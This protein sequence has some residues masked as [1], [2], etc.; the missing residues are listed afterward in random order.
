MSASVHEQEE[1]AAFDGESTHQ[2]PTS[3]ERILYG[4]ASSSRSA[5]HQHH[6][7][8]R[9][10]SIRGGRISQSLL[11]SYDEEWWRLALPVPAF[12]SRGASR[13]STTSRMSRPP[14]EAGRRAMS[15]GRRALTIG[16]SSAVKRGS[17][18]SST[19]EHGRASRHAIRGIPDQ[20]ELVSRLMNTSFS[21]VAQQS[22]SAAR[23]TRRPERSPSNERLAWP[24]YRP[25]R[26]PVSIGYAKDRT[27]DFHVPLRGD[28]DRWAAKYGAY[29]VGAPDR[30]AESTRR[31]DG[32]QA[33]RLHE[34]RPKLGQSR[35]LND[36]ERTYAAP[37]PPVFAYEPALEAPSSTAAHMLFSSLVGDRQARNVRRTHALVERKQE[38][39]REA[40]AQR[41]KLLEDESERI[42]HGA[43]VRL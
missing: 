17:A 9:A 20:S 11:D 2:R 14:S 21:S 33:V 28:R 25:K 5:S 35:S 15:D 32:L 22:D 10:P 42:R 3:R 37:P 24:P 38:A 6:V 23:L 19:A 27:H 39:R 8:P 40:A 34:T 36:I 7:T 31:L 13:P 29:P 1:H 41:E 26:D 43:R 16:S 30:F 12:G 4:S 18:P